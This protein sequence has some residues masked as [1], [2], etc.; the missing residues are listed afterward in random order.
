MLRHLYFPGVEEALREGDGDIVSNY[1]SI[2]DLERKIMLQRI[3]E[4]TLI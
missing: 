3:L 1:I 2:C 4:K